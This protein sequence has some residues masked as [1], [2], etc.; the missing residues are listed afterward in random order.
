MPFSIFFKQ[1]ANLKLFKIR[2]KIACFS[3]CKKKI[4]N[5]AQKVL[6]Q[7]WNVLNFPLLQKRADTLPGMKPEYV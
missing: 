1:H 3:F 7:V 6:V 2:Q 5:K 4:E